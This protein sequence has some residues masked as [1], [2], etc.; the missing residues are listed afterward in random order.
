L[1]DKGWLKGLAAGSAVLLHALNEEL[2]GRL[3]NFLT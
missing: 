2:L 1:K 3:G